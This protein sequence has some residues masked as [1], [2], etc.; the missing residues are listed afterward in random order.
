[1]TCEAPSLE[2]AGFHLFDSYLRWYLT[3]D[4]RV[5]VP[6]FLGE[7]QYE[8]PGD[9]GNTRSGGPVACLVERFDF[10]HTHRESLRAT[11]KLPLA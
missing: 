6:M 7:S 11:L 9:F 4:V 1:M 2:S 10:S 5:C 8:S 3:K